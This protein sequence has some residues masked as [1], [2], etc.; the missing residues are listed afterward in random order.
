LTAT[1]ST[2]AATLSSAV[3]RLLAASFTVAAVA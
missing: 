2:A 1:S 3:L